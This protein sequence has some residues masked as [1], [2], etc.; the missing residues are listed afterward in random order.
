MKKIVLFLAILVFTPAISSIAQNKS[1]F[2]IIVHSSIQIEKLTKN[3][4]SDIFLKK[5]R[6]WNNGM[7]IK[8]VDLSESLGIREDFSEAIHGRKVSSIKAYW[9][10]QIFTGKGVPP[11]EKNSNQE[12]Q[13]YIEENIGAIG[14]VSIDYKINRDKVTVVE[15]DY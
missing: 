1:S 14:Y 10:K 11:P 7:Q 12:V 4:L 13:E 5:K 8:P 6:N 15:V 3:E 9:Q 2:K